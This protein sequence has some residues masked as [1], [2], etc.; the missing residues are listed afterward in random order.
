MYMIIDEGCVK[1]YGMY[2][3]FI[4]MITIKG[5][6]RLIKIMILCCLWNI[7]SELIG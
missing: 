7:L 1:I 4:F 3:I 5:C 2:G 6:D